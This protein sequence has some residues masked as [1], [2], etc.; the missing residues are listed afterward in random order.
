MASIWVTVNACW[1]FQL[2]PFRSRWLWRFEREPQPHGIVYQIC[3][4]DLV[5]SNPKLN[6][7][8]NH[9]KEI[10]KIKNINILHLSMSV[11]NTSSYG[12]ASGQLSSA[13]LSR[14]GVWAG[15]WTETKMSSV[16]NSKTL[17][18]RLHVWTG[19]LIGTYERAIEWASPTPYPQNDNQNDPLK[20][21]SNDWS[22]VKTVN[23]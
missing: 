12:N 7:T 18:D 5:K 8:E 10:T 1:N 22:W 16:I 6:L 14:T 20:L 19:E 2:D 11:E 4:W 3:E 13:Y 21:Q 9:N 17:R 23:I 15:G